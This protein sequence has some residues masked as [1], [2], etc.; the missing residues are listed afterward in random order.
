[1]AKLRP[2][3]DRTCELTRPLL[4][5]LLGMTINADAVGQARA[6]VLTQWLY[7]K[8]PSIS[9][10]EELIKKGRYPDSYNGWAAIRKL[11]NYNGLDVEFAPRRSDGSSMSPHPWDN[12]G[13]FPF[14]DCL[15][16][17]QDQID[18]VRNH[19]AASDIQKL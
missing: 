15:T 5:H 19:P 13:G 8:L 14:M 11:F 4:L 18:W 6:Y 7:G 1:M 16:V 3:C 2:I 10:F 12:V 17:T 9:L